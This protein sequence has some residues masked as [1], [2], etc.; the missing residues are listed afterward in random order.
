MR[1]ILLF[2]ISAFVLS[3]SYN[4]RA[5]SSITLNT[6]LGL[7][8]ID[9]AAF[10]YTNNLSGAPRIFQVGILTPS[11]V[12]KVVISGRIDWQQDVNS[13][14]ATLVS[15]TTQPF[16]P[17]SFYNDELGNSDI[18][19]NQV[20]GNQ[21]LAKQNVEKGKPT[22]IYLITLNLLDDKGT[23]LANTSR[24]LSFLNPT[25]PQILSP[26]ENS[27]FD[28]GTVQAQ[29]TPVPGVTYYTVRANVMAPGVTNVDD[30]LNGGNPVINDRNVGKVEV[31]NLSTIL[32]RQWVDGQRIV[33]AVTAF[34][35]GPGGGTS[36]KSTPVTFMLN[37][38]GNNSAANADPNLIRL[39]NIL[40]GRTS[41]EFVNK[42]MNG[43][44]TVGEIKISD[45]N[46][47]SLAF[48]DLLN[49]ISFLEAHPEAIVSV[50]YNANK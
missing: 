39:G 20:N 12:K 30:A 19:I 26:Q 22:G 21:D 2:F 14:F 48:S 44:I 29:W 18:K 17:R 4:L 41:Q 13:G 35:S 37:K 50:N 27:S 8:S 10:T 15:F 25:P 7:N 3:A 36:L 1:R 11:S 31:V 16:T 42:L 9:F 38:S 5:Q 32:D 34:V 24:S 6:F 45:E 46:G 49:I 43:Q 23:P 47:K 40:S 28:V 33:L